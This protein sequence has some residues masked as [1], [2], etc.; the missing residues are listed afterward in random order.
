M[1]IAVP[2]ADERSRVE[3]NPPATAGDTRHNVAMRLAEWREA[4]TWF[5]KS[6]DIWTSLKAGGKFTSV[7]YGS[8]EKVQR[9]IARCD[10]ALAKLKS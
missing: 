1:C 6:M 4:R 2:V 5:Q 9:E 3:P 10:A 7:V 8:P